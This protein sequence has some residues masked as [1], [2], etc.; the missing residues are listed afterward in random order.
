MHWSMHP[1]NKPAL[2]WAVLEHFLNQARVSLEGDL[3]QFD[4]LACSGA[5]SDETHEIHRHTKSPK[6]DFVV[7]PVT[8]DQLVTLKHRLGGAGVFGVGGRLV[9]VQ[10]E[11]QGKLVFGGYDNFHKECVVAYPP[12]GV[13]FL[14]QLKVKGILRSYKSAA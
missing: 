9:H 7:L 13:T 11:F 10:V 3:G 8:V 1:R 14:E 2:L 4:L 5:S 6:L 12:L